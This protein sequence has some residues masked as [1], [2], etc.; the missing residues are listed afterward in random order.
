MTVVPEKAKAP[1]KE[2]GK[3]SF[4]PLRGKSSFAPRGFAAQAKAPPAPG[5]EQ[6]P[7][8]LLDAYLESRARQEA[9]RPAG[10]EVEEVLQR[11]PAGAEG[12]MRLKDPGEAAENRTGMPDRLK[13]GLERLSGADLSP[14]RV[15][16]RSAK[17]AQVKA[18]A[19]TQ[20]WNI[21]VAPGQERH[22]PHE[23]WHVVQQMAGRVK[24]TMRLGGKAINDDAGLEREADVMGAK[25]LQLRPAGHDAG[26]SA[27]PANVEPWRIRSGRG[28][29][30]DRRAARGGPGED[31][32]QRRYE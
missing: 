32:D 13:G 15:H 6:R 27:G 14:V 26:L 30:V 22:L 19:Y 11:R 25:A 4:A 5:A 10:E 7:A 2:S 12:R 18:H 20:G 3:S 16:Y 24:P 1:V 31:H 21:H 28:R 29:A 8:D 9:V 23:G 17:P